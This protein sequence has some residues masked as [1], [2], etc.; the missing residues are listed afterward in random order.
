MK[1]TVDMVLL[2]PNINTS[3]FYFQQRFS[4]PIQILDSKI[5]DIRYSL[6]ATLLLTLN[7][8]LNRPMTGNVDSQPTQVLRRS[9]HVVLLPY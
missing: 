4:H 2:D 6:S 3:L 1:S 7:F 8:Y 9:T 5:Q